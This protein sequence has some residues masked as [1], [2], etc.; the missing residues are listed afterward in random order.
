MARGATEARSTGVSKWVVD[1]TNRRRRYSLPKGQK[2]RKELRHER[3]AFAG[4]Y[5]QLL[6]EH[7]ATGDY[8]C[9]RVHKLPSDRCWWCGRDERQ[10]R[11]HLFVNCEAWRPQI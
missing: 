8:L 1:H 3:K 9:R 4:R 2:L 10:T 11:H 5:Y 7:A 6:S